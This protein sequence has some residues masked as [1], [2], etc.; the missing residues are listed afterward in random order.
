MPEYTFE[1]D[2]CKSVF[3]ITVSIQEYDT[4]LNKLKCPSCK[5]SKVYREYACDNVHGHV[6]EIRTLGQLAE[7][8]TKKYGSELVSKM[9]D[10][11]KTK[12]EEG[13]K[14]LPHGMKRVR[15]AEDFTD[16]YTKQDWLKKKKGNK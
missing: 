8:N 14:E 11:H 15:K 4:V 10:E 3:S 5:S 7:V 13:M 16:N 2:K 1:C 9:R 6:N 12:R